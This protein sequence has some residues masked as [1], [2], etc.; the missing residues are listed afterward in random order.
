MAKQLKI[1]NGRGH[2]KHDKG[3][4]YVAAY[5]QKQAT[6]L[7]SLACYELPDIISVNE[8]RNYYSPAWGNSMDGIEPTEPCVYVQERAYSTEKPVRVI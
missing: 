5:S 7:V 4:I 3:H 8:I 6:E 1:W 2:G